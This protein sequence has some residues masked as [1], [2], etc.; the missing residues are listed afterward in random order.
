MNDE[1][2]P[3]FYSRRISVLCSKAAYEGTEFLYPNNQLWPEKSFDYPFAQ[4]PTVSNIPA[5]ERADWEQY[6][7]RYYRD[8]A[9]AFSLESTEFSVKAFERNGISGYGALDDA[10]FLQLICEGLYSKFLNTLDDFDKS[11]FGIG[12]ADVENYQYLKCDLSCMKV[13]RKTWE[14]EAIAPAIVVIRR[15]RTR[16]SEPVSYDYELVA[17]ALA[18]RD[19][20][21]DYAFN[22]DLVFTPAQHDGH[23]AWW[24][25]KLFALQ[26]AI[27][28]INLVD[29]IRVHFPS[30]SI[31]AITKSVLPRWH[32]L[33]QLLLPHFWLTLPVNNSVLEGD[34]S[35]INR[36]T[37]YPWSP[38]TAKGVEIRRLIP[39][40]WGGASYCWEEPNSSY[41]HYS[42][43]LS[44]DALPFI[45]LQV[46]RFARF[47][48]EYFAPIHTFVTGVVSVLPDVPAS[49]NDDPLEWL[50]IRRW[51]HEIAKLVPGFPDQDAIRDKALLAQVCAMIIWNAAVVH[52]ADHSALHLMMDTRPVPFI[53]RVQPP[54]SNDP[55]ATLTLGEAAGPTA[56]SYVSSA[57]QQLERFMPPVL[58]SLWKE[59]AQSLPSAL[60][61]LPLAEGSVPLCWPSDLIYAKMADLLF[62]RP[63]GSSLLYDCVYPFLEPDARDPQWREAGRPVL[64]AAQRA[65]LKGLCE[66]FQQALMQINAQYYDATGKPIDGEVAAGPAGATHRL[67]RYGFPKVIPGSDDDPTTTRREACFSAGIQY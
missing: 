58:A 42:F 28:R 15:P 8:N 1:D 57:L 26:G 24:L 14:G 11:L 49:P 16:A 62:Y 44:P 46:S 60:A 67:N 55:G 64:D 5:A 52:T 56:L 36:D 66:A 7:G 45:G 17:I 51:A 22:R 29:H 21:G 4:A 39:L 40:S 33:H 25:A 35:I 20:T 37:W 6:V 43:P 13:V 31:N 38:L 50:E 27:H 10:D 47:Q 53:M 32:L 59:L 9:L 19:A 61:A 2:F 18:R 54:G 3:R 41:P 34:R 12:P 48:R 63:H 23:P 30:D 65:Q